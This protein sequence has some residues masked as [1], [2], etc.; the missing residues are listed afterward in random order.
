ME[1]CLTSQKRISHTVQGPDSARACPRP[2]SPP[3]RRSSRSLFHRFLQLEKQ[4]VATGGAEPEGSDE[5]GELYCLCQQTYEADTSEW[6]CR[7][8]LCGGTL[9]P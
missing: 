3:P 6:E 4:L 1:G 5:G 8:W 9:F 7:A 2:T